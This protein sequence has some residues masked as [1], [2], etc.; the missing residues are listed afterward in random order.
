MNHGT[1]RARRFATTACGLAW[2]LGLGCGRQLPD[3]AADEAA[4]PNDPDVVSAPTIHATWP[5]DDSPS[6]DATQPADE[7]ATDANTTP[8]ATA[9]A[10]RCG[11]VTTGAN[12]TNPFLATVP[13]RL[14]PP[15]ESSP[16]AES[17]ATCG[18]DAAC[19][20]ARYLQSEL[21]IEPSAVRVSKVYDPRCACLMCLGCSCTCP[22]TYQASFSV[23]PED[24]AAI[25]QLFAEWDTALDTRRS[26]IRWHHTGCG[27]DLPQGLGREP[28][29]R[30]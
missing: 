6:V 28:A 13:Y 2:L 22:Y 7:Q 15:W 20:L 19:R 8:S 12:S 26:E 24:V 1:S 30:L 3:G 18:D 23:A 29:E 4:S 9:A 11:I 17:V 21:E 14:G 25:E 27:P 16:S 10:V 5:A